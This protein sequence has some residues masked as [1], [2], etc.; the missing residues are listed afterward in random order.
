MKQEGD[1]ILAERRESTAPRPRFSEV[2][3]IDYMAVLDEVRA[4]SF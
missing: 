4:D 3:G 2:A 1:W